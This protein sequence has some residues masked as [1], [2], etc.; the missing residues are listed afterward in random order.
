[1]IEDNQDYREE[2]ESSDEA[3]GNEFADLYDRFKKESSEFDDYEDEDLPE[4]E[5][6][7]YPDEYYGKER[8]EF[9]E[10]YQ[11]NGNVIFDILP[12]ILEEDYQFVSDPFSDYEESNIPAPVQALLKITD[13][14]EI[15][16]DLDYFLNNAEGD[17][18][19]QSSEAI[20]L[21]EYLKEKVKDTFNKSF[22]NKIVRNCDKAIEMIRK[23]EFKEGVIKPISIE[24]LESQDIKKMPEDSWEAR[25]RIKKEK[26]I[27]DDNTFWDYKNKTFYSLNS[28]NKNVSKAHLYLNITNDSV[29]IPI[30]N[31]RTLKNEP[32]ASIERAKQYMQMAAKG[33]KAKRKP[34]SVVD[35]GDGTY[36]VVDG[37]ATT[38]GLVE[39]GENEAICR[40]VGKNKGT[41]L[42]N[43]IY[44]VENEK[45]DFDED[46][47]LRSRGIGNLKGIEAREKLYQQAKENLPQLEALVKNSAGK[48]K[49]DFIMR[50]ADEETGE[51]VKKRERVDEKAQDDYNGDYSRIVD[52]IGGTIVLKD[53]GDFSDAIK[54][55]KKSLPDGAII[56]RV[57]KYNQDKGYR[58]IKINV[59][60]SNGGLSEIIIVSDYINDAKF[61][62]GGHDV[63]DVQRALEKYSNE[64]N[65]IEKEAYEA[66]KNLTE[67][68][69]S[70][71]EG[72]PD[73]RAFERIKSI[74]SSAL[75]RLQGQSSPAFESVKSW[76]SK[77]QAAYPPFSSSYAMPSR[78]FIKYA[79]SKSPSTLSI[80]NV[81]D[82]V[83]RFSSEYSENHKNNNLSKNKDLSRKYSLG[84]DGQRQTNLESDNLEDLYNNLM[85][86]S[87]KVSQ[88][89]KD[90]RYSLAG[91]K[92]RTAN[93]DRLYEAQ[94]MLTDGEDKKTVWQKTGWY[95]AKDGKPRFEI[96]DKSFR[97]YKPTWK[98]IDSLGKGDAYSDVL[99]K[100]IKHDKLFKAYPFIGSMDLYF[101][102]NK[103]DD[104]IAYYSGEGVGSIHVNIAKTGKDEIAIKTAIIHEIQHAI[105]DFEG[106]AKGSSV[107]YEMEKLKESSFNNSKIAEQNIRQTIENLNNPTAERKAWD[108]VNLFREFKKAELD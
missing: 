73:L 31:L 16:G 17:F 65:S 47:K 77:F 78:S 49:A 21:L 40:V 30:E 50:P 88:D 42:E 26:D 28:E 62:R 97:I 54:A 69:Y 34:I 96:A 44:V 55:I 89:N 1:D 2:E 51:A 94:R 64:E 39:L 76:S 79:I 12:R 58:D 24:E 25:D 66:V 81:D 106:F 60:F 8:S 100:L 101:T 87:E 91:K 67:V 10:N 45:N 61:K 82:T 70:R 9:I 19:S 41:R 85:N 75:T 20:D 6:S 102:N 72:A 57:K 7:E 43:S 74:A 99:R 18:S 27:Y 5:E 86:G 33:E 3:L 105:Q 38:H 48:I 104:Y 14:G 35:N 23:G 36:T 22:A 53:D 4:D 80:I 92:A 103:D 37:N 29:E 15:F 71:G 46:G 83:N 98:I 68:I 107:E 13:N 108:Y 90:K 63:Y 95:I 52:L 56:A 32:R 11:K 93:I 84:K 59:R